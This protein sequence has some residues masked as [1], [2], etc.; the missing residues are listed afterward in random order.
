[1]TKIGT[2]QQ[3]MIKMDT[4]KIKIG[5]M[6]KT[7]YFYRYNIVSSVVKIG[8]GVIK[9]RYLFWWSG[10]KAKNRHF[11]RAFLEGSGLR[12]LV[13]PAK[14]YLTLTLALPIALA[15]P[16]PNPNPQPSILNPQPS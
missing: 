11:S 12:L 9:N 8:K 7:S 13:L 6:L 2:S 3:V 4:N 5:T 15:N 1:M 16:N 10:A 14:P